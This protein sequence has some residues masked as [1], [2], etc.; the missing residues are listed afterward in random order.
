MH[1]F[2]LLAK[3]AVI[4]LLLILKVFSNTIHYF[5]QDRRQFQKYYFIGVLNMPF[6]IILCFKFFV[7]IV[8]Y[9]FA[10]GFS[11]AME[12]II[13]I[14]FDYMVKLLIIVNSI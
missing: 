3:L 1:Y 7:L 12:I 5:N 2:K 14:N 11:F 4:M 10:N 9:L 6:M 8:E 13:I